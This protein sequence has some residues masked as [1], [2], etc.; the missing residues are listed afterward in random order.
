MDVKNKIKQS[1]E[2]IK[3]TQR[4][5]NKKVKIDMY[6]LDLDN[7]GSRLK[8]T[9][10]ECG[11]TQKSLAERVGL[12]VTAMNNYVAGRI[13][14]AKLMY[15]ICDVLGIRIEWI[16]TGQGVKRKEDEFNL[17]ND[18]RELLEAYSKLNYEERIIAKGK[19]FEIVNN[20][21]RIL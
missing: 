7:F 18:E 6:D 20:R 5:V 2:F 8:E 9:I 16:L 12:S 13:P 19:L 4:F 17:S 14:D 10:K 1:V 11:L 21:N 15:K 3:I